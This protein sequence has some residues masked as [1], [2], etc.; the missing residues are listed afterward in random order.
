MTTVGL[1]WPGPVGNPEINEANNFLPEGITVSYSQTDSDFSAPEPITLD[2]LKEMAI[3]PNITEASKKFSSPEVSVV[4]YACTSASYVRGMG[5]DIEISR[6]IHAAT[7]LPSTT[8]STSIINALNHVGSRRISVLSP[9]VDELNNRLR[10]FL[11]EYGFEVIHM[12][13]LNRLRGI[14]EIPS[15]EISELVEHLVDSQDADSILVS[16]TGMKTSG[17]IDQLENKIGKPVISA[18]QATIWE[19]LRLAGE[20]AIIRGRGK[21]MSQ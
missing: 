18:L 6:N 13:G 4:G 14:E 5:G 15:P 8:T 21:L 3:S 19:C 11:E 10:I 2:R 16:C 12:R 9:H 20:T 1:V 7:G 17:I